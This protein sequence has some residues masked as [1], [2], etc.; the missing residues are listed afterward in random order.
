[1]SKGGTL[2]STTSWPRIY[3]TPATVTTEDTL[4][5]QEVGSLAFGQGPLL[6]SPLATA[7][8]VSP[9]GG[10]VAVRTYWGAF[11]WRRAPNTPLHEAFLGKPCPLPTRPEEQGEAL[12][13]TPDSDGY[14]TWWG[15]GLGRPSSKRPVFRPTEVRTRS[16]SGQSMGTLHVSDR[17]EAAGAGVVDGGRAG[18]AA[19]F[20]PRGAAG[21]Q[22]CAEDE[23][24]GCKASR[25]RLTFVAADRFEMK[26]DA[27][28]GG[29][30]QRAG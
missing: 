25:R 24:G 29:I 30:Y 12:A 17:V 7:C 9:D 11:V 5:L 18:G 6:G 26:N 4:T 8:D 23:E 22:A 1:M 14:V 20:R 16:R 19:G 21:E 15:S 27:G 2:P 3:R 10:L 28:H 13:F